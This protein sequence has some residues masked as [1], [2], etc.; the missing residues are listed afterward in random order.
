M[1]WPD[2]T[3]GYMTALRDS[4][5]LIYRFVPEPGSVSNASSSPQQPIRILQSPVS[6]TLSF[7]G[8][9]TGTALISITDVLGRTQVQDSRELTLGIPID[10]S[11][12][13]VPPGAYMLTV[14]LSEG[15][16]FAQFIK[17]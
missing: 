11:V 2:A 4:M 17:N 16:S 5:L 15:F 14:Q 3:H 10:L 9:F 8:D 7:V 6:E 13:D 1:I 12:A